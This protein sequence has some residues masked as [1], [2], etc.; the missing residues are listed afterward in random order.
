MPSGVC[1]AAN[2]MMGSV[3]SKSSEARLSTRPSNEFFTTTSTPMVAV[4]RLEIV[5]MVVCIGINL[6][7]R[8]F[9]KKRGDRHAARVE[10]E[11]YERAH[12]EEFALERE[13]E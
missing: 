3:A 12:P 9:V 5:G 6:T 11:A 2:A 8:R 4:S 1:S 13:D 10:E 7:V